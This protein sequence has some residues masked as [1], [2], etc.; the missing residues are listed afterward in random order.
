MTQQA[1]KRDRIT[2]CWVS[3]WH[4][5][6]GISTYSHGLFPAIERAAGEHGVTAQ[7]VATDAI[8]EHR[9]LSNDVLIEA[10]VRHRPTLIHIQHEFGHWGGKNPPAYRFPE[11]IRSLR[12]QL[13]GAK[14][15]ATAHTVI[16]PDYR[17]PIHGTWKGKIARSLFNL[18]LLS[19][20]GQSWREKS[21]GPLDGVL[22]HSELQLPWVRPYA[23]AYC[24]PHYVPD[25]LPLRP[26]PHELEKIFAQGHGPH[27]V[28]FGFITPSKGHDLAIELFAKTRAQLPE[29]R[30]IFAGEA[31]TPDD[32]AYLETCL[33]LAERLGVRDRLDLTGFLDAADL[34]ALLTKASLVLAPFRETTGSGS[35]PTALSYGAPVLASDL[36]LNRELEARVPGCLR[37]LSE[38]TLL[39]TLSQASSRD[40]LRTQ[41]KAYAAQYSVRKTALAHFEFYRT[42]QLITTSG[43]STF[44]TTSLK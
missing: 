44:E 27:L 15:I 19:Y 1:S 35:I 32:Q 28:I 39:E 3:P 10:I 6:S 14:I 33:A 40:Q 7:L 21:W 24:I 31:R 17:F 29:A 43:A 9:D 13:P 34:P 26:L 2:L 23:R 37:F 16:P 25:P 11:F 4:S 5:R 20:L 22:V 38:Q 30:L 8:G 36:P 42:R 18:F 41:A 12:S